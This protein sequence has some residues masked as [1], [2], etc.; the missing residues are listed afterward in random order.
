M[1]LAAENTAAER[2]A[3]GHRTDEIVRRTIAQARRLADQL[4][5]PGIDIVGELDLGNRAKAIGAHAD[6]DPDD[7]A[8]VDRRVEHPGLAMLSLEARGGA[9]HAAEKADILAHHDGRRIAFEHDVHGAVDRLDHVH[10]FGFGH[11]SGF[12][13]GPNLASCS[14]SI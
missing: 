9:E 4:V 11:H 2:G 1:R 5:E 12:Q 8:L 13:S 7:P 10:R 3:H 6:R 14:A